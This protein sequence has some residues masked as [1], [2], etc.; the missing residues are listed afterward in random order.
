MLIRNRF[1]YAAYFGITQLGLCLTF[2]L[3]LADTDRD[4]GG[5]PFAAVVTDE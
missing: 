4:H 1:H 2:K 5:Q 3:R